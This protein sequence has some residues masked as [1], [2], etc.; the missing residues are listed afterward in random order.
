MMSFTG[1]RHMS[2]EYRLLLQA[3]PERKNAAPEI[4]I[5]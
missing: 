1:I 3:G 4:T 2:E 5:H